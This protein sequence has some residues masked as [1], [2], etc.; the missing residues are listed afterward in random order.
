M[1]FEL[2][3]AWCC[4]FILFMS[5]TAIG[6]LVLTNFCGCAD[7]SGPFYSERKRF[8]TGL[9]SVSTTNTSTRMYCTESF[10][11]I[12][13]PHISPER[14]RNSPDARCPLWSW[15]LLAKRCRKTDSGR[16]A[17]CE[18]RVDQN[19]IFQ[20]D[21]TRGRRR[22]ASRKLLVLPE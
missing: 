15:R 7:P 12:G 22:S 6:F 10:G 16:V 5:R 3:N 9:T 13:R 1:V 4:N 17:W 21:K 18:F 2:N 8:S 14:A 11:R 20:N 19:A